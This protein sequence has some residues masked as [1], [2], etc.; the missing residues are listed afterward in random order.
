LAINRLWGGFDVALMWLWGGFG[1]ASPGR[2]MVEVGCRM[3]DD[4]VIRQ[5]IRSF[6]LPER[7]GDW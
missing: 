2:S 7:V 1:V 4:P 6:N 3:L 5:Q